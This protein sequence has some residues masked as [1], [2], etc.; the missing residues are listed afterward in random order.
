MEYQNIQLARFIQR[1]N[2]FIAR[3]RLIATDEEVIVHVKN[4][5]RGK[6][7]LLPEALVSLEFCDNPKR[8]TRYDLIAVKKQEQWINIDSQLPNRLAYEGLLDQKI[9]LPHIKGNIVLLKKEVKYLNSKFDL[10]FETDQHEKG[11]IEVKGMTL[12]NN[13]IGAFPDAPTSRGFKH[14]SE[15]IE[16]RKEGYVTAVVFIVQFEEIVLAT[17]HEQMQPDLSQKISEAIADG[18]AIL[19]YNCYVTAKA[20]YLKKEV[21]FA[22]DFVF[23]DPNL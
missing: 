20:V 11:F 17:I 6:E 3:C 19:A 1:D 7:V 12:E 21:P 22:L 18:V 23:E 10:Y 2:R 15:L 16:A 4:T 14:V 9:M 5:G 8:K 13:G